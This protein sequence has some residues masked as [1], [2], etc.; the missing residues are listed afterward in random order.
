MLRALRYIARN[1]VAAGLCKEPA[2]W[3]WS[4]YRGTA[5]YDEGFPFVDPSTHRAYFGAEAPRSIE[6]LRAF[7]EE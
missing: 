3:Q 7:V 1:P 4:S 2:D 6:L 5:G